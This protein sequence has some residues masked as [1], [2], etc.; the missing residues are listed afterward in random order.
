MF[1]TCEEM[2][3]PIE[4]FTA[5]ETKKGREETSLRFFTAEEPFFYFGEPLVQ[6]RLQTIL[7]RTFGLSVKPLKK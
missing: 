4:L 1:F 7:G 3:S 2:K 5:E 6:F